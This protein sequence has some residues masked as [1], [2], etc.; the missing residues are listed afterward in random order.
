MH[1]SFKLKYPKKDKE[2]LIYFHSYFKNEGKSL[3]YSAREKIHPKDWDFENHQ[4]KNLSGRD[5]DAL[6][7]KSIQNQLSKFR[8]KF[9]E[10]VSRYKTINEPLSIDIV[11]EEFN[12]EF[13]NGTSRIN[14]FFKVY[15]LFLNEKRKDQTDMANTKSTIKRY[16]YNENLLRSFAKETGFTLRLNLIGKDF[17]NS[18]IN[19]CVKVKGHSANTLSRNMGLIKTFMFWSYNNNY[20]YNDDFKKFKVIKRFGTDEIALTLDQVKDIFEFDLG[21]KKK[22]IRV[23]DLFVFGCATGLRYGNYSAVRKRDIQNGFINVIDVKDKSKSLSIPLN[24]FSKEILEK[25]EYQ[26]PKISNQK[27]NTYLKE[28]FELM[29]YTEEIKKTMR[30]GNELV[31]TIS[32]VF[33]RISSHTARRTFITVM[34]NKGVPDK[35]IMSYTGHRSLSNFNIY[36]KPSDEKRIDFM[37]QVWQ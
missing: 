22:L 17:Y 33:E 20:T 11:R 28:L 2:S 27:F 21:R 23:R 14:D 31:E 37:Q 12:I 19:Y 8:T 9:Q 36:Y 34:K 18:F 16:E 1:F 29:G 30:Y 25:Y 7:R 24:R 5:K 35:V 32:P 4:P 10:I 13:S 6:K 26:L 15:E 3:I